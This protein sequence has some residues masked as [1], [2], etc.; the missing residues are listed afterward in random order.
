MANATAAF[1]LKHI[2]YLSGQ[3]IDYQLATRSIQSS[4]A[5]RLGY[6]DPVSKSNATSPYIVIYPNNSAILE[7]IFVGCEYVDSNGQTK[8]S[9]FW[10]GNAASVDAT[11]F[12]INAPGALFVAA[13][14]NTAISSGLIGNNIGVSIGTSSGVGNG[15]SGAT[16]DQ[17][18]ATTTSTLPFQIV[19]LWNGIGNGSDP[20]TAFNWV[21]VTFNNQRYKSL[22]GGV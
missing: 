13:A 21:V 5:P 12:I 4:Y 3:A 20:T 17:S 16:L 9:S 14:T 10:P 6:G 11:A 2:G 8:R 15:F 18:T 19:S 22:T 7:G 1:G